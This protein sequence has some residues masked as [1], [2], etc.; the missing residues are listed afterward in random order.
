V[1]SVG[2][3]KEKHYNF[4]HN[5]ASKY[6]NNAS[7]KWDKFEEEKNLRTQVLISILEYVL[8]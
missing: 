5:P 8:I 4:T 6:A 7:G 1:G 3:D 2:T